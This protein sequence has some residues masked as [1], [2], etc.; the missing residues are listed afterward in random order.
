LKDTII[1]LDF[2]KVI[3]VVVRHESAQTDANNAVTNSAEFTMHE[4]VK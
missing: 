4:R 1:E 3:K 2:A